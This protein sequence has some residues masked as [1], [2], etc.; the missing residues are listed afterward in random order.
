MMRFIFLSLGFVAP[1]LAMLLLVGLSLQEV[2]KERRRQV[3][4]RQWLRAQG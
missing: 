2:R 3:A 4:L 1:A